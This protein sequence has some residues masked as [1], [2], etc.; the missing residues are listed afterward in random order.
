MEDERR[1]PGP[2][3]APDGALGA[4]VAD[5]AM[6]WPDGALRARVA[7]VAVSRPDGAL[8][9]R[10]AA[11]AEAGR[12]AARFAE[13]AVTLPVAGRFHYAVPPA[14]AARAVVGARV[15]VRFGGRKV[16]GVVVRSDASP[17]AGV[18]PVALSEVLDDEPALSAEL[19]EL[20]AWIADYYEAPPGEVIRAALPAGSG[21]AARGVV[22]L[23]AAGR[24]ALDGEGAAMQPRQRA[25]LARIAA[26]GARGLPAGGL[27]AAVKRQLDELRA[28]GMVEDVEQR[29]TARTRL[30]RERV[31]QLAVDAGAACAAVARAPRRLA[32]VERL[33]SGE[34]VAVAALAREL[35]G[36]RQAVRELVKLGLAA[37]SERES[38]IAAAAS[39]A[40]LP[41]AAPP[42]LT[43]EQT[44]AV[45]EIL[46]A[47]GG[48]PAAGDRAGPDAE[49]ERRTFTPFLLHGV[50]GSG[51]TEVYLRVIA[52]ALAAGRTALVL[53]PEI[54]LTPQLAA[55]FRARFGDLVAILHSGLSETARLGEWS[56]LRRGD[57]RI[58]VGARSAVFAP[59]A[60]LGVIVVDEEHDGSFKQ[61]E[62]VRYHARDVALVRAQRAGAVCVLGS[63]TPSLESAAHAER[64]AYRKLML[65]R[66]PTARPMPDVAIIDLRT[67]VPDGDAMLSAPLRAAIGETLAAGDQ[68]ILFLN[69]R[70]FATF[71]LCR[72]CGHAFRCL[73]CSV[74]LTY[75]R[76][77]DRL[78]CHY[79]GFTQRVP[80]VCPGCSATGTIERKGLGTEKVADAVATAFPAARVARLDRDVASG[81]KIEAVLARVARREV[82]VLVGTQMVTK[83][84]DFPGVTLVGVLC[85]DTG[86]DLPDFR[87]SERTFQL[88]AQVAGR[89][90]RGD[91]PGRVMIQ[92]YRPRS[93]AVVAAAAHDY[94]S[95]F[96]AE[97]A[98]RAELGYPPHGRLVAVRIDGADAHEVAGAAQRLAELARTAAARPEVA[99]RVEVRGPVPAPLERLRNRTRWQVWLRSADRHALR[100]V[101]RSLVTADL[102]GAVRVGLDV[103][104]MSAM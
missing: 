49:S 70:G 90:G 63:A 34:A 58:A 92:T 50:T 95:F 96:A 69:R 14:L 44:R 38:A 23:T 28:Q 51:K 101:A 16:T 32:V 13:V 71:V 29:A 81:A 7:D 104:P 94:A 66:R 18:V 86:L 89:A 10:A 43:D 93:P 42:A 25:L 91:R 55:R 80:E 75:H 59:L 17:P 26:L 12:P 41:V 3:L 35:V 19:V 61:D 53:V 74:S 102:V 9:A 76:H 87:A 103:D 82:D 47:L 37:V 15:L 36:A 85:A 56:R 67:F 2:D 6:P 22:A 27:T 62:G 65:T 73:H 100:R 5:K 54:S 52:T 98:A 78:A 4:R 72:A 24:A 88:L 21:V 97:S 84:H 33:A 46:A 40:A 68:T 8:A 48:P 99:G 83:G 77:S 57:A 31:V 60:G 64:G 1:E 45:D 20:C 30:R 39:G 11:P 79:C